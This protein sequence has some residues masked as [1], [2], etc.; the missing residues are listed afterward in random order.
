MEGTQKIFSSVRW[1]VVAGC[2]LRIA[3][4]DDRDGAIE[5]AGILEAPEADRL[6]MLENIA[7]ALTRRLL[8]N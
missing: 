6:A 1:F 8:K 3:S 4:G 5:P 2:G 7:W